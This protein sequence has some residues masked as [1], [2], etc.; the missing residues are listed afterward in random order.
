MAG[1]E[2]AKERVV[3]DGIR[4]LSRNYIIYNLVDHYKFS[5]SEWDEWR[6]LRWTFIWCDLCFKIITM[7]TLRRLDSGEDGARVESGRA[8]KE[9]L[10]MPR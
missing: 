10:Q 2:W 6:V 7:A 3:G 9:L 1:E 4:E 5:Y 8:I